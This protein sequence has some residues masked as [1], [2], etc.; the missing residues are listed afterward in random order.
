[1]AMSRSLSIALIILGTAILG[2]LV[3]LH[4][5]LMGR[6][7]AELFAQ[8]ESV[9]EEIIAQKVNTLRQQHNVVQ[10]FFLDPIYERRRPALHIFATAEKKLKEYLS[11]VKRLEEKGDTDFTLDRQLAVHADYA[12][13]EVLHAAKQTFSG[14]HEAFDFSDD[15]LKD[16]LGDFDDMAQLKTSYATASS[17][18]NRS[19]AG[20]LNRDL[21]TISV[22]TRLSNILN[23][24]QQNSCYR[25][26]W[27]GMIDY[28]PVIVDGYK[29]PNVGEIVNTRIAIGTYTTALIPDNVVIVANGDTLQVCEDGLADFSFQPRK[30]GEHRL[31]LKCVVTNPLTGE[32]NAGEGIVTFQ[33]N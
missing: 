16:L 28:F 13:Q 10:E 30:R 9:H 11:T 25:G 18:S 5:H 29:N 22:L 17:V 32:V 27:Y 33:V 6:Q 21:I 24:S 3:W 2:S 20:G 15:Q 26:C 12:V 23:R 1:M 7:H 31:P 4:F 8:A 14:H 19:S